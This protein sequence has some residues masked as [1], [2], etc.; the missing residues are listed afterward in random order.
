MRKINCNPRTF[1]CLIL[2]LIFSITSIKAQT[3]IGFFGGM[4]ISKID[5]GEVE[6]PEHQFSHYPGLKGGLVIDLGLSPNFLL[7]FEPT[8]LQKGLKQS[9]IPS[10]SGTT[11]PSDPEFFARQLL[12]SY[13]AMP[14]LLKWQAGTKSIRPYFLAGGEI[15]LLTQATE[16]IRNGNSKNEFSIKE[17]FKSL[18]YGINAGFGIKIPAGKASFFLE[19]RKSIGLANI[20]PSDFSKTN[21]SNWQISTGISFNLVNPNPLLIDNEEEDLCN[22]EDLNLLKYEFTVDKPK[23][24]NGDTELTIY[25]NTKS[26]LACEDGD[27]NCEGTISWERVGANENPAVNPKKWQGRQ[28]VRGGL[29][30]Q[31]DPTELVKSDR[32]ILST[33]CGKKKKFNWKS[34]YKIKIPGTNPPV[35]GEVEFLISADCAGGFTNFPKTVKLVIDSQNKDIIDSEASD[36][37]GDGLTGAEEKLKKTDPKK[38]DSD[39]DGVDDKTDRHPKNKRRT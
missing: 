34:H 17:N 26:E 7:R 37:D 28:A 20:I 15:G 39:G 27:G 35:K 12:L 24:N 22:C 23:A 16:S 19:G 29:M 11:N 38:W 32:K 31:V 25:I 3:S 33:R 30:R 8:Y 18:D 9:L 1:F 21:T 5:F 4:N 36:I 2:S 6:N 14:I 13:V 10:E